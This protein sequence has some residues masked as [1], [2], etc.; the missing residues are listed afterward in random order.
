MLTAEKLD[1]MT[2]E[3]RTQAWCN[4]CVSL[5]GNHSYRVEIGRQ[6]GVS[7]KTIYRWEADHTVP[8][9]AIMLVELWLMRKQLGDLKLAADT[10][11]KWATWLE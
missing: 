4:F 6:I 5:H 2:P 3:E 11:S 7:R 1:A 9:M 8:I 10:V